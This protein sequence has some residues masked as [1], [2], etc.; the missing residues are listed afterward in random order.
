MPSPVTRLWTAGGLQDRALNDG[1]KALA[2]DQTAA[3]GSREQSMVG[4]RFQDREWSLRVYEVDERRDER[5]AERAQREAA[6][7]AKQMF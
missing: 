7:Q 3:L 6:R 4:E 5:L 1:V 2:L